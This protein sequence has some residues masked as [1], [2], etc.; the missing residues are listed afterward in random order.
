MGEPRAITYKQVEAAGGNLETW[1]RVGEIS[2]A[3]TPTLN[4]DGNASI[5]LTELSEAK[6]GQI[7][8]L[9]A[10]SEAEKAEAAKTKGKEK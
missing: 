3:G 6:R 5:D 10:D 1:K 4:A 7:D 8:K 9:L 2:G